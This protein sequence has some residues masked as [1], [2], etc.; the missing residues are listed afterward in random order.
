MPISLPWEP[1]LPWYGSAQGKI[2]LT[3][4]CVHALGLNVKDI[5]RSD[6]D[7]ISS[8]LRHLKYK[9]EL[10]NSGEHRGKRY[11]RKAAR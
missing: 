10:E 1:A 5:K 7:E 6:R 9:S 8:T 11:W 3:D 4:A 2:N